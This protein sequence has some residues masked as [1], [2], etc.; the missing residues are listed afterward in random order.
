MIRSRVLAILFA[1][2]LRRRVR[3]RRGL[4]ELEELADLDQFGDAV[5]RGRPPSRSDSDSNP[6]SSGDALEY[7]HHHVMGV[8]RTSTRAPPTK[9]VGQGVWRAGPALR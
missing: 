4:E 7:E 1:L 6:S 8:V 2:K 5:K 9:R 3:L